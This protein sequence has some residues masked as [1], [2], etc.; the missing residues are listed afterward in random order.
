M[1]VNI[2]PIGTSKGVRLPKA[3]LEQCN[4]Q[5]GFELELKDGAV[6]LHPLNKPRAGWAKAFQDMAAA[7]DDILLDAESMTDFDE[8]DWQW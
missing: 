6:V 5:N 4:A 7:G 2:I 3:V 8:S 1:R